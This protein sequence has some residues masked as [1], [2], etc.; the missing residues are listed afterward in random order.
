MK[1]SLWFVVP[2]HGRLQLASICLRQLRRTCDALIEEG[3]HASA[4]VVASP[5]DHARLPELGFA[6]IPRDNDFLGRKFN[7]GIQLATDPAYNPHPVDYVVPLGSDDWADHRIFLEPL[8][9]QDTV[10]GFQKVAF[11]REDGSELSTVTIG[12]TGGAGIR[13][14]PRQLVAGLDYRPADDD[15][16]KGCDTSILMNLKLH[17][18]DKIKVEHWH[19]HDHQIVDWKTADEQLNTYE[20]LSI[21]WRRS[22]TQG[23]PFSAL[24]ERYPQEALSEMR[25]YYSGQVAA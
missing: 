3:V 17:H 6:T 9:A 19:L 20:S 5:Q 21:W 15:R 25:A 2:V 10:V 11:V 4:V 7:D 18:G 23:D 8:P 1:P 24:A 16:R 22:V 12:C 13:I 14:I